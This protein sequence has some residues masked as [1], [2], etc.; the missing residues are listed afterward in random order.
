MFDIKRKEIGECVQKK[1]KIELLLV[2]LVTVISIAIIFS[3]FYQ[4]VSDDKIYLY[5][6]QLMKLTEEKATI[7]RDR[8]LSDEKILANIATQM[9]SSSNFNGLVAINIL[10]NNI[11][12]SSLI[13]IA[14]DLPHGSTY[15]NDGKILDRGRFWYDSVV[16]KGVGIIY[17]QGTSK[18]KHGDTIFIIVPI[19]KNNEIIGIVRGI[20][21]LENIKGLFEE[22]SFAGQGNIQ[23]VNFDGSVIICST[24]KDNSFSAHNDIFEFIN[25]NVSDIHS[26]EETK[27]IMQTKQ[28]GFLDA[29]SKFLAHIPLEI[30]DWHLYT[31]IPKEIL[32]K[33]NIHMQSLVVALYLKLVAIIACLLAYVLYRQYKEKKKY[34]A[35]DKKLEYEM[36]TH[37]ILLSQINTIVFECDFSKQ[38][39]Q[40]NKL[41]EEKFG[42]NRFYE[43][44]PQS[45]IEEK[46]IYLDDV[47]EFL[48]IYNKIQTAPMTEKISLRIKNIQGEFIWCK[49]YI[50][51]FVDKNAQLVRAIGIINDINEQK[52]V[53][54]R[55][56]ESNKRKVAMLSGN[57]L[58]FEINVTKDSFLGEK[59][60]WDGALD[61]AFKANYTTMLNEV[62]SKAI[63]TTDR[64]K[65]LTT[66]SRDSLLN[67]FNDGIYEVEA[68]YRRANKEGRF[69]WVKLIM[70]L[71]KEPASSDIVAVCYLQDIH[72]RKIKELEMQVKNQKDP[73]TSLYNKVTI[74][75]MVD[76]YLFNAESRE[77]IHAL[78]VIDVDGFEDI[79]ESH[80]EFFCESI[81]TD[82]SDKLRIAFRENDLIARFDTHEFVVFAKNIKD[83]EIAIQKARKIQNIFRTTHS[84]G[85]KDLK[86]S[87]SIGIAVSFNYGE[88]FNTMYK[89]AG[90]I[91]RDNPENSGDFFAIY[92]MEEIQVHSKIEIIM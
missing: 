19:V 75:N 67:S 32:A 41:F 17:N 27:N 37:Q 69:S 87:C 65:Y 82:I 89:K 26:V 58:V 48:R 50:T 83:K 44:F 40:Y 2:C 13:K 92:E 51:S 56:E 54:L 86:I 38:T 39:V 55:F 33:E 16:A 8:L 77:K 30:N 15:T 62:A 78:V 53:Q 76:E 80:G 90:Q 24:H 29:K 25:K 71:V 49:I 59:E 45:L 43:N 88:S 68:E 3:N 18:K 81:L 42:Y 60:L 57:N 10:Q 1:D 20:Y 23:I 63:P 7:V 11:P 31:I 21:D 6:E 61:S 35:I 64:D 46:I 66:F 9:E 91:I 22:N 28:S 52:L 74:K 36:L 79:M 73:L 84:N 85:E 72:R 70:Y 4:Q 12:K 5:K 47:E 14:V 34:I